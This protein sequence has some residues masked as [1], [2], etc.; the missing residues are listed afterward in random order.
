MKNTISKVTVMLL[1]LVAGPFVAGALAQA[2]LPNPP[3]PPVAQGAPQGAPL[4]GPA[5][6][7]YPAA[8]LDRIV[9]PIALYPDPLLAQVLAAATFYDQIP[10][11]ARW[12]DQHH[13]LN[14][15][16]LT[17]AMAADQIPWDPSVQALI[18]FPSVL[19]MMASAM[20]WTQELGSAFLTQGNEV[21]DAVQRE[22]QKAASYGYLSSNPQVIV[23]TGPYIEILP[24]NPSY[25]VVPYYDPLIVFAPP[26]RGLV[27]GTA[28]RFG[29]GV[30]LTA[31]F[32]PW[33]WQ[34]T[35]FGWAQHTVIINNSPWRRTWANHLTY[36]HPYTVPRYAGPRPVDRHDLKARSHEEREQASH[37]RPPK[38]EHRPRSR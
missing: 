14:G 27:V 16:V 29:F 21:M 19:D 37:G 36:V 18:P 9:S 25:I 7:V 30:T 24:A 5:P 26:R 34:A 32:Q 3:Q 31:A 15:P 35:H 1:I 11:A 12:A 20:P 38:E 22:R 6:A 8:E 13:Y 33:G 2:P 10:D 17:A 4:P 28:I 23:R